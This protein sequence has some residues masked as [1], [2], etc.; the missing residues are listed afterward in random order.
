[1]ITEGVVND[2]VVKDGAGSP[3]ML[4]YPLAMFLAYPHP[5]LH[6]ASP[7]RVPH[8]V[9][10][11]ADRSGVGCRAARGGCAASVAF[12]IFSRGNFFSA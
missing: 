5:A 12:L 11:R 9:R 10:A 2:G 8:P 3:C 4:C 1:M 6:P 7:S